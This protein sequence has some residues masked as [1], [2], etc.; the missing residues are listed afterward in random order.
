MERCCAMTTRNAQ[1]KNLL[2]ELC[3]AHSEVLKARE[4][5]ARDN[6]PSQILLEMYEQKIQDL[7]TQITSTLKSWLNTRE[8][9]KQDHNKER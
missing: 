7:E 4:D 2:R 8:S 3:K 5:H 9:P 6:E 1:T